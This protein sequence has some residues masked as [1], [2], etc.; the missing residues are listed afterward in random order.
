MSRTIG[1][2]DRRNRNL[3]RERYIERGLSTQRA[4]RIFRL[5]THRNLLTIWTIAIILN[6]L[7]DVYWLF[8]FYILIAILTRRDFIGSRY[9]FWVAVSLKLLFIVPDLLKNLARYVKLECL[10]CDIGFMEILSQRQ[11]TRF[12]RRISDRSYLSSPTAA[13]TPFDL[14]YS[15]SSC[16]RVLFWTW[17]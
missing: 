3:S 6:D 8:P 10:K 13:S 9:E 16:L 12:S 2:F 14:V 15:R 17:L 1:F 7:V 11:F 5:I 4:S